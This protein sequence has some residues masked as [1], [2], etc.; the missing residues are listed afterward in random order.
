[1]L[2]VPRKPTTSYVKYALRPIPGARANGRLA[3]L[4]IHTHTRR[5]IIFSYIFVRLGELVPLPFTR[6]TGV[7]SQSCKRRK[8]NSQY[9]FGQ[10][11]TLTH[12]KPTRLFR[13]AMAGGAQRRRAVARHR[14]AP[15][16]VDEDGGKR[17]VS[18]GSVKRGDSPPRYNWF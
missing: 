12:S 18:W 10:Q 8:K 7:V 11:Q 5:I 17:R 2:P 9:K 3:K 6:L 16:G 14:S 13:A 4:H 1:M 15:T